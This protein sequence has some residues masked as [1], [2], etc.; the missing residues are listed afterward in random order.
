MAEGRVIADG[1]PEEVR[2]DPSVVEAYL[3]SR[4]REVRRR[5]TTP[6]VLV[7]REASSPAT[8]PDVDILNG[9]DLDVAPGEIVTIVGPNG[10]G[11]STLVKAVFG[12]LRRVRATVLLRG[13]DVTGQQP[14][15]IVAQGVGYVPQRENVFATPDGRREPRARA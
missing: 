11:K 5:V 13:E 14:H 7:T 12:L 8:S 2:R 9:V 15:R 1:A 10:A 6:P 4:R 3:G